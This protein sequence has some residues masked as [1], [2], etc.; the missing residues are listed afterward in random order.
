MT[1][2]IMITFIFIFFSLMN[3]LHSMK[4]TKNLI[5]IITVTII[6]FF[7]STPFLNNILNFIP[8]L[9]IHNR[10]NFG[11]IF[12]HNPIL[13]INIFSLIIFIIYKN[14]FSSTIISFI[15]IISKNYFNPST[16]ISSMIFLINHS[17]KFTITIILGR[18]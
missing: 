15:F 17:T 16:I 18:K 5:I 8:N 10:R 7:F 11:I 3:K 14:T 6:F 12:I 4:S 13:L 1:N 2:K 9:L